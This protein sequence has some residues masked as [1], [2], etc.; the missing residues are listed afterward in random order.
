M[1]DDGPF[2]L[3]DYVRVIDI[4]SVLDAENLS[5]L[6]KRHLGDKVMTSLVMTGC[7]VVRDPRVSQNDN[8]RFLDQ[9][10]DYFA[11]PAA[12]KAADVRADLAYQVR[13]Y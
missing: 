2:D 5:P 3:L 9:M 10:E 4:T 12:Q 6:E 7:V 11:R 1:S 13:P 8:G